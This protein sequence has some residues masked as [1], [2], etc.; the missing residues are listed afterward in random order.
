MNERILGNHVTATLGQAVAFFSRFVRPSADPLIND[1]GI[2]S[3]SGLKRKAS[4]NHV[5]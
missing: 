4:W 1:P 3:Y 2:V 5:T